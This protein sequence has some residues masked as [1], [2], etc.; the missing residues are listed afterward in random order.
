MS[1]TVEVVITIPKIIYEDL[2]SKEL[3]DWFIENLV[4]FYGFKIGKAIQNGIVLPN[5]HGKIVD[6]GKID[7]DRIE[8]YNP[9]IYL[10]V[11]GEYIEA[12]NLDYLNSLQAIIEED[13]EK[14]E[15]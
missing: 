3:Q 1:E 13:K 15:K 11:N 8:Q 6:L 14:N 12:V 5:G 9:V 10:T 4:K 7:K 2:S